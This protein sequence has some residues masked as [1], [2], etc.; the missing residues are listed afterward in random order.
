MASNLEEKIKRLH[1]AKKKAEDISNRKQRITGELDGHQ[2][3]LSELEKKCKEEYDCEVTDLPGLIDQLEKE[4]DISI[5]EAERILS[6]PA[7]V[8]EQENPVEIPVVGSSIPKVL[9]RKIKMPKAL[10]EEDVL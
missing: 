3:R 10:Q 6:V 1:E 4:A 2:K 8:V 5:S 7:T 9:E